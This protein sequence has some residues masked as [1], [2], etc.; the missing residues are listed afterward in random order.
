M[1]TLFLAIPTQ[2]KDTELNRP[3][4]RTESFSGKKAPKRKIQYLNS[5]Q[6][7]V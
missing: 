5:R 6:R 1:S 2:L 4:E 7:G 3:P